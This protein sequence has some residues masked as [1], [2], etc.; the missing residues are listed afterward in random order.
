MNCGLIF[1]GG[2]ILGVILG[3]IVMGFLFGADNYDESVDAYNEGFLD[4]KK[5]AT[6]MNNTTNNEHNNIRY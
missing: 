4:G 3:I 6:E 1:F 5:A 2:M